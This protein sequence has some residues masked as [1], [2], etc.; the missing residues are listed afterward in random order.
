MPPNRAQA[1]FTL[2]ELLVTLAVMA[3]AALLIAYYA[4]PR[5]HGLEIG[6]AA[7]RVAAAMRLD[8]GLAIATGQ[9]VRFSLPALPG[10][11]NA[12]MPPDGLVFEPDGSASGGAVLLGSQ[13]LRRLIS[14]DWLTGRISVSGP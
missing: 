8:R 12:R 5:S 9:P 3:L 10:W 11:L 6:R 2:L 7:Q 4:Q 13:G 14:V 1:G